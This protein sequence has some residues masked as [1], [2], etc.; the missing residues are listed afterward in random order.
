M[1]KNAENMSS[2]IYS[3]SAIQKIRM[4]YEVYKELHRAKE[5]RAAAL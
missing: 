1:G 4:Q 3:F 2:K 5:T